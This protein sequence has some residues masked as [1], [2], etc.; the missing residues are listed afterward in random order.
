MFKANIWFV[1]FDIVYAIIVLTVTFVLKTYAETSSQFVLY[2]IF[3]IKPSGVAMNMMFCV[4]FWMGIIKIGVFL[5]QIRN[6]LMH[7]FTSK[8]EKKNNLTIDSDI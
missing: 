5:N 4:I 3:E 6:S 7:R 1:I 2:V 8:I